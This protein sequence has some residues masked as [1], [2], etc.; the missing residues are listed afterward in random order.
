MTHRAEGLSRG[1]RRTTESSVRASPDRD[2]VIALFP[3]HTQRIDRRQGPI[4]RQLPRALAALVP[5][6]PLAPVPW[7][8]RRGDEVAHVLLERALEKDTLQGEAEARGA[9]AWWSGRVVVRPAECELALYSNDG[10]ELSTAGDALG[11]RDALL[12]LATSLAE[13]LSAAVRDDAIPDSDDALEAW[14]FDRDNL[15]LLEAGGEN[16]SV[17]P[18]ATP[19]DA[20][21]HLA[22]VAALDSAWRERVRVELVARRDIWRAAASADPLA[23]RCDAECTLCIDA[24]DDSSDG[25]R[26]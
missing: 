12:R 6:A 9:S 15:A 5:D 13:R 1:V 2:F 24:L 7:M 16:L 19:E 26:A 4:A 17:T 20:W 10:S 25:D 11:L 3:F 22:R 23:A 21:R 14:C 18:L 8:V